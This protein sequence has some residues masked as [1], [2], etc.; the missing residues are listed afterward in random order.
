MS[1]ALNCKFCLTLAALC[2][3]LVSAACL[4][5]QDTRIVQGIGPENPV[6]RFDDFMLV[7][8]PA[9]LVPWVTAIAVENHAGAAVAA[10][11]CTAASCHLQQFEKP[12]PGS[13]VA[14]SRILQ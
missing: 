13:N 5:S 8:S 12:G 1:S 4:R 14:S 6:I 9:T 3:A 7:P 11:N 10:L 2:I